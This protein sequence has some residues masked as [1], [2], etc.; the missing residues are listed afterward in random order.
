MWSAA[1][2]LLA[3]VTGL[4]A[5]QTPGSSLPDV[6]GPASGAA[7]ERLPERV[8]LAL[9]KAIVRARA[10]WMEKAVLRE[11]HSTFE[12]AWEVTS[13]HYRVR[14]VHSRTLAA[15][16]CADL[17]TMLPTFQSILG[18]S[19]A[20]AEPFPI[21]VF[22]TLAEYNKFGDDHGAEHSSFSGA[23]LATS[24]P[25]RPVAI[26]FHRDGTHFRTTLTHSAAHQFIDA[27]FPHQRPAW[28]DEAVASY[29]SMYWD[30]GRAVRE[31]N[32]IRTGGRVVPLR[33]LMTSDIADFT[34]RSQVRL[35][36]LGMWFTYFLWR[37]EETYSDLVDGEPQLGSF[38][39]FVQ[40]VVR[41]A[42]VADQPFMIWMRAQGA[43]LEEDFVN[44]EF[45]P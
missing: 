27:A 38:Q 35:T 45:V 1:S 37:H 11:D 33:D 14:S 44:Y 21:F 13:A 6:A 3:A 4:V 40:A 15:Q 32:L 8:G 30:F 12:S 28:F 41:G 34:D 19:F 36:E 9:D 31:W 25:E 42:R 18:T 43:A 23:F 24:H 22:Q 7:A 16:V 29:F 10:R 20:P 5:A 17:E 26:V 2:C 39:T